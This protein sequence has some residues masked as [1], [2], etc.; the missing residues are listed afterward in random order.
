V[1]PRPWLPKDALSGPSA[2]QVLSDLIRT[3]SETWFSGAAAAVSA[4]RICGQTRS[5]AAKGFEIRGT[6]AA[7][8]MSGSG[9]Q[10]LLEALLDVKLSEQTRNDCDSHLLDA[11]AIEVGQDL[12]GRL[13]AVSA[14]SPDSSGETEIGMTIAIGKDEILDLVVSEDLLVPLLKAR[15]GGARA[16]PQPPGSRADALRRTSLTARA[17]LGHADISLEEIR[18]LSAGDILIL[19]RTLDELVELRV[20]SN[21]PPVARGTIR[22]NGDQLSIQL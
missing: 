11:L 2:R 12:I 6:Y 1:S 18:G 14:G 9:K 4:V 17:V 3:W 20:A 22:R 10:C 16:F 7:L 21:G 5:A 19:D 15:L 8:A 13:D